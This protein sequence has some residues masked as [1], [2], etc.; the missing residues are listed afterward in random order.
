MGRNGRGSGKSRLAALWAVLFSTGVGGSG[1]SPGLWPDGVQWWP[2]ALALATTFYIAARDWPFEERRRFALW[3]MSRS[4]VAIAAAGGS[5]H[6][7]R[8]SY[9][10][11]GSYASREVIRSVVVPTLRDWLASEPADAEPEYWMGLYGEEN[12]PPQVGGAG[13]SGLTCRP[14]RPGR[15]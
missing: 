5:V 3:L 11:P 6:Q 1:G 8:F 9:V 15:R 14:G 7:R 12:C 4:G 13:R 10:G 2:K